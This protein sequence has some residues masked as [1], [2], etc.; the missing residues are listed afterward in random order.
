MNNRSLKKEM[1][2]LTVENDNLHDLLYNVELQSNHLDQYSRRSHIEIRNISE[3]VI[4][5]HIENY[6]LKVMVAIDINL[7]S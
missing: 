2:E 4:Q 1:G 6:V 5:R 3:K 7:Q